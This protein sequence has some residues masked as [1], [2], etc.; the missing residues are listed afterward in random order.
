M[1]TRTKKT[2]RN[3]LFGA[4]SKF[5]VILLSFLLRTIILYYLGSDYIGVSSVV[6]SILQIL[7]LAELGFSS[8]ITY[9]LYKPISEN[10]FEK[11][12]AYLNVFK[13]VYWIIGAITLVLGLIVLPFFPYL[14]K[15]EYSINENVYIIYILYLLHAVLGFFLFAYKETVLIASQRNDIPTKISL[16]VFIATTIIQIAILILFQNFYLYIAILSI[17]IVL[18]NVL[19]AVIAKKKFPEYYCFGD[20]QKEE[21]KAL[22]KKASGLLISK[23]CSTTR[24]ALDSIFISS[25]LGLFFAAVYS[26]YLY[27]VTT[28]VGVLM[29]AENAISASIGN[30]VAAETK[31]KNYLD[32]KVFTFIFLAVLGL[33]LCCL[34][35]SYQPFMYVWTSKEELMLPNI[36]MLL[37]G[38]YFFVWRCFD[39]RNIY[40]D[41]NGLWWDLKYRA[42]AETIL[43][44]SLNAILVFLMGLNGVILAT[45]ISML[46]TNCIYDT[47]V[48]HKKYFINYSIR[49]YY[50]SI[51]TY[52]IFAFLVS[53]L[54]FFLV[55]ILFPDYSVL[56]MI[57]R[58]VFSAVFFSFA[59]VV[60]FSRTKIFKDTEKYLKDRFFFKN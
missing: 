45:I 58:F 29:V 27:V 49:K 11:T 56:T 7:N 24:N 44:I 40:L 59:F 22:F 12:R 9:S 46:L 37:F 14:L 35:S 43:N 21:K 26:N 18:K 42:I 23:L 2:S 50:F 32:Y 53:I 36:T 13:K 3:F 20:L 52:S 19:V 57:I 48:L 30:S 33:F 16:Y 6:T 10:D 5:S 4:L 39:V 15:G 1:E 55:E 41:V 8:A 47:I 31:E 38:L 34:V 54:C 25:V 28:V 17:Q 60:T 51:G